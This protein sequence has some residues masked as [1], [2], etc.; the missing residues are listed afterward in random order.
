MEP[1]GIYKCL[2]PLPILGYVHLEEKYLEHMAQYKR[3]G[4]GKLRRW[5]G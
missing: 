2:P 5:M 4:T 3:K 1:E